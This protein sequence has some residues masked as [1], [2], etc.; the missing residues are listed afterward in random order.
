MT[1]NISD[2]SKGCPNVKDMFLAVS[3]LFKDKIPLINQ[4]LAHIAPLTVFKEFYQYNKYTVKKPSKIVCDV[5]HLSDWIPTLSFFSRYFHL[6]S[7]EL[8]FYIETLFPRTIN[9]P[10]PH[11]FLFRQNQFYSW[12]H[13]RLNY[14][15]VSALHYI[16]CITMPQFKWCQ[17]LATINDSYLI[18]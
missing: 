10:C 5:V 1:S 9:K 8:C 3:L 12:S 16:S 17:M 2:I 13:K 11:M 4:A 18:Y 15:V 6:T 7:N 14:L